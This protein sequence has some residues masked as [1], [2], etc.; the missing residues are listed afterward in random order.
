MSAP[1]QTS[2]RP[3]R[4][5]PVT[6]P[7]LRRWLVVVLVLF[8]LEAIN[9]VWLGGV[10]VAENMTG[11]LLQDRFYL[12]MFA[13]HLVLGLVLIVPFLVFGIRHLRRAWRRPNRNAVRA[14][15]GL[16][17]TALVLLVSGVVLTRFG[18]FEINDQGVRAVAYWAHVITPF[19]V[20][21]LFV[22]HRLAG[23]TL[24]WRLGLRWSGAAAALVVAMLGLHA[25][26][27]RPPVVAQ[28]DFTPSL[29]KTRDGGRIAARDLLVDHS[30]RECHA[31]IVERAEHS[32]HR[33]SSFNNPA[34]R[35][36]V[37]EARERLHARDGSMQ[38]ARFCAGCHDL[39]PLLSGAFD[40]VDFDT[41][42][43]EAQAGIGCLGCHAIESVDSPRG[44]GDFTIGVPPAYPF[45]DSETGL[46]QAIN[47]Q[48][49]RA[50]P[51][52]HK[53]TL[54]RPLH[55][56]AEFCATCHK[57][58]L[59]EALNRYRWLRGQNHY[60]SFLLSGVSGHR[61]DSFYYPKQAETNCNRCHMPAIGADD[62]AARR[63]DDRHPLAVHDHLFP[64]GNTGVGALVGSPDWANTA[65]RAAL[66][67]V[68][69]VDLFGLKRGGEIDGELLAPLRPNV[70][71]LE[72]GE[73]YLL[74]VVVRT[75]GLGHALTQGTADSNELWVELNVR[76]GERVIGTSGTRDASGAV[77]PWAYFVNA[78]VLDRDGNRIDRRNAQD[79]FV[80]L[81]NHQI[82]PGA[83]A[84][85]HYAIEVPPDAPG[86]IDLEVALHYR[87][88]DTIYLRKLLDRPDAIND[89]PIVTMAR[90]AIRL[91]V[92]GGA[93]VAAV[94][95]P[96]IPP[97]QRW[98]DYGI[99]LLREGN[100]GLNK[101][102][103]RQAE[104]AF[105]AVEA[106]GRADGALNRARVYF[107]EGRLAEAADAL[108]AAGSADP[109][110][111]PWTLAWFSAQIERENGEF[112][113]AIERLDDLLATN[114]AEARARGFDF[115]LDYRV[116]NLLGRTLF[117]R[118]RQARGEARA[119]ERG[120]FLDRAQAALERAL[121]ID[122][123]NATAHYNLALVHDDRGESQLAAHHRE[124]HE[125]YKTD[126]LAIAQAVAVHRAAN[127]AADHAAAPTAI[128][129]LRLPAAMLAETRRRDGDG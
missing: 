45:A 113:R 56:S 59:P 19:V 52:L 35:F 50:K 128:Y 108:A 5:Q 28:A 81:Y 65:R 68:V 119:A 95:G 43:A 88:F 37:N 105:G 103:L 85:V 127:P 123:E 66:E 86:P 67:D 11:S 57:V 14:G 87:K 33:L 34:Y 100:E 91:P 64:S 117:E 9:S 96:K 122:P 42:G 121:A 71:V 22:L 109:P 70:P 126:E 6:G 90:D 47:R 30:C 46:L 74:E 83:A 111:P 94:E 41:E 118:S 32:A 16:F 106:L 98:N 10:T 120:E 55:K 107:K 114:Y 73:R 53:A 25:L 93:S 13:V 23:P 18:F 84:V 27:D 38:A 39:V 12:V 61:V 17:S 97:W 101:G 8:G 15:L 48:L 79:I 7:R 62:P 63:L 115:A 24:R 20:V 21:W 99:G 40:Q 124:L 129:A 44:N 4:Y 3:P 102:Q 54:L 60:D 58:H 82:P 112:D 116:W 89:L 78:Y 72:P 2:P 69:R 92:A 77:D 76:D 80:A 75:T 110:A 104:A 51:E 26:P 1:V 125:R 29:V 36:A 31:D 49:I